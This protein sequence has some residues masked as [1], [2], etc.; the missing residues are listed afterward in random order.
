MK[1]LLALTLFALLAIS[2]SHGNGGIAHSSKGSTMT[3][4]VGTQAELDAANKRINDYKQELKRQGFRE[5]SVAFSDKT[6]STS[7]VDEKEEVV[8]EGQYGTLKDL[9]VTLWT[10]KWL[11]KDQPQLGG[12]VNASLSGEQA[13]RDFNE[14]YKKVAFVVTGQ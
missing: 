9:R 11:Q 12:R 5:V 10:S 7:I 1:R 2:C 6:T 13:E 4:S 14:L 8:F 3:Y